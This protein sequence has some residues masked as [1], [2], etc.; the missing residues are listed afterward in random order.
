MVERQA[1]PIR[2]RKA[3]YF[4]AFDCDVFFAPGFDAEDFAAGLAFFGGLAFGFENG[5]AVLAFFAGSGFDFDGATAF[6]GGFDVDFFADEV[7]LGFVLA[8]ELC[9]PLL[10]ALAA[11][12]A[13]TAACIA[14]SAA[15]ANASLAA[16]VNSSPATSFA[17]S[18]IISAVRFFSIYFFV[19]LFPH[20]FK[21][22]ERTIKRVYFSTIPIGYWWAVMSD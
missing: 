15:P 12:F 22:G 5:A 4:D 1:G 11:V 7:D 2:T 18:R 6:F 10:V 3:V 20:L 13:P 21:H 16:P 9:L 17:L 19:P 8:V 14:E